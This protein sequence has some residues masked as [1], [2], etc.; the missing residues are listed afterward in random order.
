M[1]DYPCSHMALILGASLWEYPASRDMQQACEPLLWIT[2]KPISPRDSV[3]QEG[4]TRRE[5]GKRKVEGCRDGRG[6]GKAC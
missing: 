2:A 5:P 1:L 6:R 4:S 3:S